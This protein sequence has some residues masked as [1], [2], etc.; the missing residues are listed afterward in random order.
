MISKIQQGHFGISVR[1]PLH[2]REKQA[3]QDAWLGRS[4]Q[5]VRVIAV[6]DGLGSRLHSE[7]GAKAACQAII[8]A[9]KIWAKAQQ[10]SP[11]L[12]PRLIVPI[13][14]MLISP[15]V[16]DDCAATC[17]FAILHQD[18]RLLCG[19]LGD[20]LVFLRT[21]TKNQY[22]LGERHADFGNETQALGCPHRLKD[23][24][25]CQENM[26]NKNFQI[27]LTSDGIA[28]DLQAGKQANFVD[29]LYQEFAQL[30]AN[31]RR[32]LL[33]KELKNWATPYHLDDK[34]LALLW[35]GGE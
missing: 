1:G 11:D 32:N 34:T 30:P 35:Q 33:H 5:L 27:A 17:L 6:S 31:K 7:Q 24:V 9:A 22:V 16:A 8:Q 18:G 14:K 3:N 29:Y 25:L 15:L 19:G 12:L 26:Q 28:D 23:W 13:W 4:T 10:P 21:A 2:Q 20:G